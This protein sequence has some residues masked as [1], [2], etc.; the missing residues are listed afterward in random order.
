MLDHYFFNLDFPHSVSIFWIYLGLAMAAVR[1]GT[2]GAEAEGETSPGL[3]V[4]FRRKEID[5]AL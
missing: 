2:L 5:V 3:W 1:L 4:P